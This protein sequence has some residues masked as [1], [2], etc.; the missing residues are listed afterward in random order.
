MLLIVLAI[1][2]CS[3]ALSSWDFVFFKVENETGF[4]SSTL[5]GELYLGMIGLLTSSYAFIGYEGAAT[6]AEET[7][8]PHYAAPR[9]V[10]YTCLVSAAVGLLALLAILFG[11]QGNIDF[12]LRGPHGDAIQNLFA[13]VFSGNKLLVAIFT[14]LII[15]AT[16]MTGFSGPTET[17]LSHVPLISR[18]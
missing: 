18:S 16:F 1:F 14:G 10:I 13:L 2:I 12:I 17:G 5:Q 8:N 9:G 3:P 11:A 15:T 4:D 7:Q 6:L